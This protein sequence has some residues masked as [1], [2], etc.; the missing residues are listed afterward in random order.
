M[1]DV[2]VLASCI[3]DLSFEVHNF[4]QAG[5]TISCK[6]FHTG[7][8]GKGANQAVAAAR[9][10][11]DV[12]VFGGVGADHYGKKT[13]NNFEEAGID[14]S[15]LNQFEDSGTGLA[16]I[17][18]D[19]SGENEIVIAPRANHQ[20]QVEQLAELPESW[21]DVAFVAGVLELED[22]ILLEAFRRAQNHGAKT[23]LNGAPA[24]DISPELLELVDC[25]IVNESE[26]ERFTG[27]SFSN[28]KPAKILSE[29]SSRGPERI[30]L[31]LGADGACVFENDELSKLPGKKTE[32]VD[33]TGAGDAFIGCY[34]AKRAAG[35]SPPEAV[36]AANKYAARTVSAPGTQK[37]FPG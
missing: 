3:M 36:E 26:A 20:L 10:G 37:S 17:Y 25:F 12:R 27:L 4:P 21:F 28:N 9:T 30:I 35:A 31:T 6:N 5:E 16:S 18:V 33:T 7:F 32:V 29:L 22:K 1:G 13:I 34:L 8:G 14:C 11:A 23:V 24:R 15:G 2:A 19:E